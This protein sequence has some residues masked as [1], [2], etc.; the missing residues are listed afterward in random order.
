[1]P[2]I[3]ESKALIFSNLELADRHG[4]DN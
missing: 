3:I 2:V 1:V 4:K